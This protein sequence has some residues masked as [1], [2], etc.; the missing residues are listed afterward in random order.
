MSL[1]DVFFDHLDTTLSE[2]WEME[3]FIF[4]LFVIFLFEIIKELWYA[5]K[6]PG[7]N[8]RIELIA[9]VLGFDFVMVF[10][11]TVILGSRFELVIV[12][13]TVV[14][15]RLIF[16][17]ILRKFFGNTSN[18]PIIHENK[19][20]EKSVEDSEEVQ[21]AKQ[22]IKKRDERVDKIRHED[23]KDLYDNL[24]INLTQYAMDNPTILEILLLYGYISQN[25]KDIAELNNIFDSPEEIA[26]KLKDMKVLTDDQL[27]EAHG[28]MNIVRRKGHLVPREEA[29]DLLAKLKQKQFDQDHSDKK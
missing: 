26:E 8:F 28:I 6:H 22:T 25:H 15:S 4:A 1:M 19:V 5:N 24:P 7:S 9:Q 11:L 23:V 20:E 2:P 10:A 12:P 18:E 13:A 14:F 17:K 27:K 16:L 21:E 29:M 3:H